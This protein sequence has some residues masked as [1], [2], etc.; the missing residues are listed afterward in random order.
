LCCSKGL[1]CLLL[2]VIGLRVAGQQSTYEEVPLQL[3][4]PGIGNTEITALVKEEEAYLPVG[5]LF[6][7]LKIKNTVSQH[8]D[9]VTGYLI[10]PMASY[11][12]DYVNNVAVF[13][14]KT[15][16]LSKADFLRT[17]TCLYVKAGIF[18]QV[19]GLH[20]QFSFRNL[21][22]TL[23]TEL[24]LPAIREMQLEKMRN[25]IRQ[26][27]GEKKADTVL[28]RQFSWLHLGVADWDL[29][30][31]QETN[32]QSK[33]RAGLVLGG[34]LASGEMSVLLNY[35]SEQGW[36]AGQQY[37]RW[38]YVNNRL[39]AVRQVVL[40][41]IFTQS[42]GTLLAPLQGI[43]ISNTPTT[44]R[45]SFGS[46]QYSGNTGPEWTVELYLN[47][48][49]V[50]YTKAD[51]SGAFSFDIPVLYG[52][53]SI[54][55]KYFGP[56]G[57]ES[58]QTENIYLPFSF[59]PRGQFE[60]KV[61]AAMV[62]DKE[63]SRFGRGAFSYG[64]N[65]RATVGGGIEYLSSVMNGRAMPFLNASVRMGAALIINGEYTNGVQT[66]LSANYRTRSNFQLDLSYTKFDQQQTAKMYSYDAEKRASVFMPF[67]L[68]G[69]N[70]FSRVSFNQVTMQ[71]MQYSNLELLVS[72]VISGLSTN[73]KT[74]LQLNPSGRP[75]HQTDLSFSFRL[76]GDIRFLPQVQYQHGLQRISLVKAEIEKR[77]FDRGFV[78]LGY[79]SNTV[80]HSSSFS[81]G[82][83]YNFSF[84]QS[85]LSVRKNANAYA[86]TQ[87]ARGSVLYDRK[88]KYIAAT[89]QSN[90][91]KGSI[92]LAP[93]LDL[94]CNGTWE[95]DEPR[96][97][98]LS[99]RSNGGRVTQ[100]L[101]DTTIVIVGL[102][103]YSDYVVEL[104]KSSFDRVAWQ[105][106]NA[107]L[108]ISVEPNRI[109]TVAVPVAVV[110][111]VAGTVYQKSPQGRA[112]LAGITVE[113]Y[114]SAALLAATVL[115]EQ[116]GYFSFLGLPP[117]AYS[118]R[119][120]QPQLLRSQM[121][122]PPEQRFT[123][124]AG[125]EGDVAGGLEF[126]VYWLDDKTGLPDTLSTG[127]YS[128]S[129]SAE[130]NRATV[131]ANQKSTMN[132]AVVSIAGASTE[133]QT[134]PGDSLRPE[135]P[136]RTKRK[137]AQS[138]QQ[139]RIRKTSLQPGGDSAGTAGQRKA[140]LKEQQVLESRHSK[141]TASVERLLA[142]QRALI[143]QQNALI[144]ELRYLKR[145]LLLRRKA[146]AG[147]GKE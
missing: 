124:Q 95:A 28:Q 39:S 133:G 113:I 54:Q 78:N 111:E 88:A 29:T 65:N 1:I 68:K 98:G 128:S 53:S 20:C 71:A 100:N 102:E 127:A 76:P 137:A 90:A 56:F 63:R 132:Q 9:S 17:N 10:S 144:R 105:I 50:A 121:V 75:L 15:L 96:A 82:L 108:Q 123:I 58:S 119:I 31:M 32:G 30:S 35:D 26:L 43:Q 8:R 70:G 33:T 49:L 112:P 92:V 60:Y 64:L 69:I 25:N 77:I 118:A 143:K 147:K 87:S 79:E 36:P 42:I 114:N 140:L 101:K 84:A 126:E 72:T 99:L 125:I 48:T 115:T 23:Q 3:R 120:P 51:A 11:L 45:K 27:N 93:F 139:L 146:A 135:Q 106:Q 22:V 97:Y 37:F 5:A 21:S 94:N 73:L 66:K 104:D 85:V 6:D 117:G 107:V 116:D 14:E 86:F 24:E 59:L 16:P 18:G 110:G 80:L 67:R 141:A 122:A 38:H 40:G 134:G 4:V 19:F 34:T 41:R 142:E 89:S 55:L 81:F 129:P 44:Y 52:N 2:L 74:Y 91:G 62:Q 61:T 57:E 136:A 109:K 47:N 13:K 131:A 138:R 145:Q 103:A 46:Y 83:R 12:L 130:K 7:F